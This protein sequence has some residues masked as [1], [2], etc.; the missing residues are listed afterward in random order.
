MA[1][2]TIND[3]PHSDELDREA[4]RSIV[5]G[6]PTGAR[7]VQIDQVKVGGGRIVDYPPG[8]GRRGPIPTKSQR[9]AG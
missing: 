3:L 5:G 4:M 9:P 6:G 2:I 8:F 1:Q 7:P